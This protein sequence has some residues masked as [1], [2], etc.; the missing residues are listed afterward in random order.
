VRH[1]AEL[2]GP[3][4][5]SLNKNA[6]VSRGPLE[7]LAMSY[8]EYEIRVSEFEHARNDAM[9]KF[10]EA[11]PHLDRTREEERLFEAGYRM[12]WEFLMPKI[13]A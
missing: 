5:L 9:D 12:A 4:P 10:F 13:E 2:S 7:G 1:N 6:D 8:K 3:A 11:R